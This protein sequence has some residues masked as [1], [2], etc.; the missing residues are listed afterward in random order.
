[1]T[2][3]QRAGDALNLN[4]HFHALVLDGVFDFD[5][6][7]GARFV[8]LSPPDNEEVSPFPK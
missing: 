6:P 5:D 4:L 8:L 7:G 2:F 1:V 3:V